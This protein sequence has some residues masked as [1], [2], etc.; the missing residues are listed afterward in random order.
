MLISPR[1][2]FTSFPGGPR[3][4]FPPQAEACPCH[5]LPGPYDLIKPSWPI[6]LSVYLIVLTGERFAPCGRAMVGSAVSS[7]LKCRLAGR[8]G[9]RLHVNRSGVRVC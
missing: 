1:P 2:R 3:P 9:S 7:G 6:Y 4:P 5:A 8:R